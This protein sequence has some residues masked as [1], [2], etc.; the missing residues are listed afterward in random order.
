MSEDGL[1]KRDQSPALKQVKL[2]LQMGSA[3]SVDSQVRSNT[4]FD[5]IDE[6]LGLIDKPQMVDMGDDIHNLVDQP[7][8][9]NTPLAKGTESTFSPITH[10]EDPNQRTGTF[11]MKRKRSSTNPDEIHMFRREQK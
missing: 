5:E 9:P 10:E 3:S 2:N 6:F 11:G 4:N 1:P 7:S 8:E